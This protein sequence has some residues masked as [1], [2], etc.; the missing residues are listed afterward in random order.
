MPDGRR[1]T[2][3]PYEGCWRSSTFPVLIDRTGQTRM[4]TVSD[5]T[6]LAL[7]APGGPDPGRVAG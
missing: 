5:V 1:G 2:V 3:Q 6:V 7:A 4:L